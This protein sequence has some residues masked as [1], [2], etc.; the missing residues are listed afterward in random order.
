MKKALFVMAAALLMGTAFTSCEKE[1]NNDTKNGVFRATIDQDAKIHIDGTTLN[2]EYLNPDEEYPQ[3]DWI[4]LID[5][6]GR[7]CVPYALR[8]EGVTSSHG[9]VAEFD[10]MHPSTYREPTFNPMSES[11]IAMTHMQYLGGVT[12]NSIILGLNNFSARPYHSI[13]MV[14]RTFDNELHFTNLFGVLK[15]HINTSRTNNLE[16]FTVI[17]DHDIVG[18]FQVVFDENNDPSIQM[19]PY[20]NSVYYHDILYFNRL[21]FQTWDQCD[22]KDY[23]IPIFPNTYN[24]F[25][26]MFKFFGETEHVIKSSNSAI[27][28][29]RNIM[30]TLNVTL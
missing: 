3:T 13:P 19:S 10:I 7:F 23:Y 22:G 30:H 1:N 8:P 25:Q 9:A 28:F 20:H 29:T 4:F 26:I 12:E 16:Y 11:F 27:T 14:C 17:T 2:W 5:R 21:T 18:A 15:L 24:T 6:N